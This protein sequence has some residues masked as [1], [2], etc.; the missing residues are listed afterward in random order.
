MHPDWITPKWP[1]PAQVRAVCTTRAG[2][3]SQAPY[4]SLNLGDHVG[5]DPLAVGANR[6]LLAQ[7]LDAR[8]VFLQQI[9][10]RDIVSLDRHTPHGTPGDACHTRQRGVACTIMIADC[11]PLLYTDARGSFVAAAHAGWRGLAGADGV[12]VLE[13]LQA[14]LGEPGSHV[15]VWLGPCIGPQAFEVG[16]EVR[17]AF[18]AH[19]GRAAS[20]FEPAHEAGK[21][22]ADLPSLARQR[23]QALGITQVYGNDGGAG[24]C[25]ATQASRF[26]SHRRDRVSGRLAA[27]IWLT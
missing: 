11:L 22:L 10:G 14:A 12:G 23:L 26:F 18:V 8:P 21:W 9:H 6:A 17:A 4:D 15:M 20:C 3:R 25:T 1:A 16:S 19:D 2:G 5:D 24:W 13:T 27:C 7:A